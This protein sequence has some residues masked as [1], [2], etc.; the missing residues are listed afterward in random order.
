M[1]DLDY[2]EVPPC[3]T[4]L[5]TEKASSTRKKV[6][7]LHTPANPFDNNSQTAQPASTFPSSPSAK[8][9]FTSTLLSSTLFLPTLP[10]TTTFSKDDHEKLLSSREPLSLPTTTVNF[11]RFVTRSGPVFWLQDRIEEIIMWRRG[12]K[13]TCIFPRLFLLVPNLAVISVLLGTYN[14]TP[15]SDTSL[16]PS[17]VLPKEGSAEW[18]ANLQGIQNLM[19]VVSDA[20]D[21]AVPWLPVVTWNS[22]YTPHLFTLVCLLTLALLPVVVYVPITPVLLT[23]GLLPMKT[24]L[25]RI[26]DN[27]NLT[28]AQ[29]VVEKQEVELMENERWSP[30]T[31]WSKTALKHEEKPWTSFYLEENDQ[32]G[33]IHDLTFAIPYDWD[34]IPTETWRL[35]YNGAFVPCNGD[36]TLIIYKKMVGFTMMIIGKTLVAT[37]QKNGNPKAW[38]DGDDGLI[39]YIVLNDML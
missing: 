23:V 20:H 26:I 27:N 10:E 8:N 12:W 3:A 30:G 17:Y 4:A 29:W 13:V 9:S 28:E 14:S 22:P 32:T 18:F 39:E 37:L 36:E 25:Q 6:I 33:D 35:D 34:F 19:G 5:Q 1:I 31:G 38:L 2:V 11:R 21:M 15:S 16:K 24:F 7:I